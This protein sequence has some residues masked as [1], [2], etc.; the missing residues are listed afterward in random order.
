ME[1]HSNMLP[2]LLK[3]LT[4]NEIATAYHGTKF[5][6]NQNMH[7]EIDYLKQLLDKEDILTQTISTMSGY[8][9]INELD[10]FLQTEKKTLSE[11]VE[12]KELYMLK[13]D[14]V[15]VLKKWSYES[16]AK[17]FSKVIA[18]V[19][20]KTA[21]DVIMSSN[22]GDFNNSGPIEFDIL[23]GKEFLFKVELLCTSKPK[24][25]EIYIIKRITSDPI[26]IKKFKEQHK[27]MEEDDASDLVFVGESSSL[28]EKNY[29][30]F[31]ANSDILNNVAVTPKN[32]RV[33]KKRA[34]QISNSISLSDDGTTQNSSTKL[35]KKVKVKI[36][37]NT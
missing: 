31:D 20:L 12:V 14:I 10:D 18:N 9:S 15:D 21:A 25:Y 16:C 6:I 28:K 35:P 4:Q 1:K 33:Y 22:E 17:C 37:P 29:E 19:L 34:R 30:G 23:R 36:E 7:E 3:I 32:L 2:L 13:F 5:Y 27:I 11:F 8:S 26:V 24:Q